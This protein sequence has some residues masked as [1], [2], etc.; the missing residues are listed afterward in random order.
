MTF[1]EWKMLRTK[2]E[3]QVYIELY[4]TTQIHPCRPSSSSLTPALTLAIGASTSA[5]AAFSTATSN[6]TA[7]AATAGTA[8]LALGATTLAATTVT[9]LLL[10][11]LCMLCADQYAPPQVLVQIHLRTRM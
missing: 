3:Q 10:C 2:V 4:E 8:A 6:T 5:A 7:S 11:P 1:S 9:R